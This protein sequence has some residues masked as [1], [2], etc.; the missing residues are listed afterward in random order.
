MSRAKLFFAACFAV[1]ALSAVVSTAAFAGEWDVNNTKLVG[2][3]AL[4]STALVLKSGKLLVKAGGEPFSI[5]CKGHEVGLKKGMLVAG[6]TAQVE[7]ITFHECAIEE[8]AT[9]KL[10]QA[11]IE[12]VPL[13]ALAHLDG[14]LNTLI[15][16]TP[17][18]KSTFATIKFEGETCA[19]LGTASV[20]G[21]IHIL[22]H[23]GA[24]PR[25]VHIGLVFSL[26]GALK[27]GATE[28]KLEGLV[29]HLSLASGQTW[30][31]L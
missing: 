22:F 18:T 10:S 12:T 9:C 28:A 19:L 13:S 16:V 17:K 25:A 21:G 7:S 30:N 23:E 15:L 26:E 31:F 20:T 4:A 1:C 27:I 11:L 5:V 3:A 2:T 29:T 8:S 6:D 24:D 14:T